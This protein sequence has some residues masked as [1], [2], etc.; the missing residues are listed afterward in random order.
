MSIA[1]LKRKTIS[2]QNL[3]GR[4]KAKFVINKSSCGNPSW[5][6]DLKIVGDPAINACNNNIKVR[7]GPGG[8][9]SINGRHRNIGRVGQNMLMSK[10][11][12]RSKNITASSGKRVPEYIGGGGLLGEYKRGASG[13][14]GIACCNDDTK[15]VKPSVLTT[16][17]MLAYK[18]RSTKR[19]IPN[20]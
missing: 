11:L 16:K 18:N 6:L 10:G 2:K 17:G 12:S 20:S 5:C 14:Y 13:K 1:T 8:G 15:L 19:K 3:S 4:G 9:F 7:T